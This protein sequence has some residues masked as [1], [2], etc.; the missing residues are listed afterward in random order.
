ML[1]L[2]KISEEIIMEE[3]KTYKVQTFEKRVCICE[4]IA[5]VK[6]T[7]ANL[8]DIRDSVE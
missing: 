6:A 4:E 5:Q 8:I 2:K 3:G 7:L 1:G